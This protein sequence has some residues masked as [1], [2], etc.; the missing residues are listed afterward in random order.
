[1]GINA[2]NKGKSGEYEVIKMVQ[3]IYDDVFK[4]F[5]LQAPT[6][7]RNTQQY[8]DG[9]EDVA[10]MTWHS[11]EVKRCEK[12][13]LGK[14]WLQCTTQAEKAKVD[15]FKL[16]I[17]ENCP[18]SVR[19]IIYEKFGEFRGFC[20]CS[21]EPTERSGILPDLW[22]ESGIFPDISKTEHKVMSGILPDIVSEISK[23]GGTN[24]KVSMAL[25]GAPLTDKKF[26]NSPGIIR[27]KKAGQKVSP[28]GGDKKCP[29][30]LYRPNGRR[31]RAMLWGQIPL[32]PSGSMPSPVE[33]S[34]EVF[35]Q[36]FRLDLRSRLLSIFGNL[37]G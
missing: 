20:G 24:Q 15:L 27:E 8:A 18:N 22:S 7:R 32:T 6:L 29:I 2:R 4:D 5:W 9:G 28:M 21:S 33:I 17:L 31:W 30:L 16:E 12:I 10:G 26:S 37:R 11:L 19:K 35:V 13:E 23:S 3:A 34:E 14:W 1:M 36:W 25:D